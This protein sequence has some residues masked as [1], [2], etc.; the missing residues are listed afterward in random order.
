M[1][2]QLIDMNGDGRID[3]VSSDEE[4]GFWIV[5][6]NGPGSDL[7][8][9]GSDPNR[10]KSHP[11]DIVWERRKISIGPIVQRLIEAGLLYDRFD[12][13]ITDPSTIARLPLG[14]TFTTN[15]VHFHHCYKWTGT[16]WVN[17]EGVE[18]WG[19]NNGAPRC[20]LPQADSNIHDNFGTVV[21]EGEHSYVEW[22]LQDVNGDGHPD[23][24]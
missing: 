12:R 19:S 9:L 7:G 14:R 8:Q 13:P 22:R 2:R 17:T 6:L 5:Y 11:K 21:E 16:R 3:I 10:P 23:V 24:V 1:T 15:I 18:G 20:V 4:D